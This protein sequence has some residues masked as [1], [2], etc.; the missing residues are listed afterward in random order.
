MAPRAS[1]LAS[2]S[3]GLA[4]VGGKVGEG[5]GLRINHSSSV[6]CFLL[7]MGSVIYP[8]EPV[9]SSG[10]NYVPLGSLVGNSGVLP[11][12]WPQPADHWN[13]GI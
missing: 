4:V 7:I 11:N 12:W 6:H 3:P 2:R 8:Q 9:I 13:Q 5:C 1:A 10:G